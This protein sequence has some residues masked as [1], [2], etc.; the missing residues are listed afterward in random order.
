MNKVELIRKAEK[1]YHDFCYESYKLFEAGSWLYKPVKTVLHYLKLFEK[2][3]YLSVLDLG[4]GVGR[5][6]IP[7][8]ESL[9]RKDGKVVCVDILESA[10]M[11]LKEYCVEHNV[12]NYITSVQ[13]EIENYNIKCEEYDFIIAVSAIEHVRSENSLIKVLNSMAEG[14][15]NNGINLL[16]INTNVHEIDKQTNEQL[17]PMYE[18]NMQTGNMIKLLNSNYNGWHVLMNIVKPLNYEIERNGRRIDLNTD[19]ITY[20]VKKNN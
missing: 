9:R 6:S 4:C 13:C 7:I 20:V 5:N 1:S 15:K 18:I 17:Q 19:C 11:K 14:T 2:N 16:I 8:A 12:E 3:E 10:L